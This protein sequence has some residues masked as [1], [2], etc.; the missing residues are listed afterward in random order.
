[1]LVVVALTCNVNLKTQEYDVMFVI[2]LLSLI[3]CKNCEHYFANLKERTQYL[4]EISQI[5][6]G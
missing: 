5:G 4:I 1:M 6:S 2:V 3:I